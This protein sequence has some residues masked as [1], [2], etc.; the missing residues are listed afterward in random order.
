[1]QKI[2]LTYT[3]NT[4]DG[5]TSMLP[6]GL[7]ALEAES[8]EEIQSEEVLERV[9][10]LVTLIEE[11]YRVLIK[12]GKVLFSSPYYASAQAWGNPFTVRGISERSLNFASK[13][14]RELNKWKDKFVRANFEVACSFAIEEQV[15]HRAEEV[16]QF[17]MSRYLNIAQ[18]V[19]LHLT[20]KPND[21]VAKDS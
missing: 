5:F 8:V 6:D 4:R 14:W 11:C 7:K 13:S 1:M 15:S 21:V 9:P 10:D 2:Y 18:A 17:W 19:Y 3:E 20:K 12:D 16:R